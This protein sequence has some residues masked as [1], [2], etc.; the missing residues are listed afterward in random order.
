MNHTTQYKGF[1]ATI[2]YSEEDNCYIG[3]VI[4]INHPIAFHGTTIEETH[5]HFKEMIDAYPEICAKIGIEPEEPTTVMVPLPADLY[6]KA[7][8][9]AEREGLTVRSLIDQALHVVTS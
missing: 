1:T 9:K 4:G 6:I 8:Q 7:S 3:E 5:S 2:E